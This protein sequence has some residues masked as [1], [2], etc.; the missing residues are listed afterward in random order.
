[1]CG[2]EK[3][4]KVTHVTFRA[5]FDVSDFFSAAVSFRYG[6][7]G[8]PAFVPLL[9]NKLNACPYVRIFFFPGI[10]RTK[11][12]GGRRRGERGWMRRG[13]RVK[14]KGDETSVFF[15]FFLA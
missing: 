11:E 8:V 13:E 9:D 7:S 6:H 1:M 12:K 15:P 4:K 10:G 2:G 5:S 14:S 3:K